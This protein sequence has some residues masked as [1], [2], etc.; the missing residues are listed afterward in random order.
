MTG[1]EVVN[2][3]DVTHNT[4]LYFNTPDGGGDTVTING[5]SGG[6]DGQTLQIFIGGNG[7]KAVINHLSVLGDQK[8][9]TYTQ[10]N[11]SVPNGVTTFSSVASLQYIDSVGW[12]C[13]S[14][15]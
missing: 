11:L 12:L 14:T 6:V 8:I 7:G 13:V 3:L 10:A 4:S 9:L 5:L 1:G 15:E 2:N